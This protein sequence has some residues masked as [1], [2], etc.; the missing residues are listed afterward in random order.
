MGVQ[1]ITIPQSLAYVLNNASDKSDVDFNYL[2]QTAQRESALNPTAKAPSSSAVGLFQFL[3]S[4]WLQVMKEE[5]PRLGYQQYADAITQDKDGDYVIKDKKL[6]AEVLKLREDPQV[7]ADMAAAFTRSNGAYLQGK[8][9]RMPS[10][11][12]LYIAHFLGPQG[13]EKMFN[14]GLDN[15]DQIAARLFPKQAKANPQIFYADGHARTV[16]EVYKALVAKHDGIV[17]ADVAS[18]PKFAAQQ[19]ATDPA[20]KWSADAVPSRFTRADMSFNALFSTEKPTGMP[21]PLLA[22]EAPGPLIGTEAAAPLM[23]SQGL[24][25]PLALMPQSQSNR[26]DLTGGPEPLKAIDDAMSGPNRPT[27]DASVPGFE[28]LPAPAPLLPPGAPQPL[29]AATTT[30]DTAIAATPDAVPVADVPRPRVLMS[31]P[32]LTSAFV[33]QL[34]TRR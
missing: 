7:A 8:F 23:Q 14:A 9:G 19:M 2:L 30:N 15:P 34:Y 13:A 29:A 31:N 20:A 24:Q 18:D 16:R 26:L 6:R 22:T 4:T 10:P 27:N 5:G 28:P 1:P 17:A 21:Q 33:T 25:A 12:E 11:G 3:D 32:A